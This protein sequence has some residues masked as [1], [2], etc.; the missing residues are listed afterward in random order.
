MTGDRE[1][2]RM[3]IHHVDEPPPSWG[4]KIAFV[5]FCLL[6]AAFAAGRCTSPALV[7]AFAEHIGGGECDYSPGVTQ[8]NDKEKLQ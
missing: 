7:P 3:T 6:V 8:T 1:G 2:S 5:I 4:A